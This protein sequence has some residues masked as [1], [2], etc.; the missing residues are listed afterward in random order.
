[1]NEFKIGE[2]M[3]LSGGFGQSKFFSWNSFA[4]KL[5]IT[6]QSELLESKFTIQ[7]HLIDNDVNSFIIVLSQSIYLYADPV[8]L[9]RKPRDY[10]LLHKNWHKLDKERNE[11]IHNEFV[12]VLS[13]ADSNTSEGIIKAIRKFIKTRSKFH[14]VFPLLT[15]EMVY[16]FNLGL[17]DNH[18]PAVPLPQSTCHRRHGS[19]SNPGENIST[20]PV[21]SSSLE[22]PLRAT[23]KIILE[24]ARL[25]KNATV[26]RYEPVKSESYI[27][28]TEPTLP[29]WHSDP[30]VISVEPPPVIVV[31][32]VP[33][34]Q[35][36]K[37]SE[38]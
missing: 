6:H 33:I 8:V 14:L 18:I 37:P 1:M 16:C 26:R 25:R 19:V 5:E 7:S 32:E 2:W 27:R 12:S 21:P 36:K 9:G 20:T 15:D 4:R 10:G 24:K 3:V 35:R 23:T 22:P 11:I 30:I 28:K 13:S 31:S 17:L 38:V 29:I 34:S